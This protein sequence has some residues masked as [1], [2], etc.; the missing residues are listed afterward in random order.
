LLEC[1]A[2]NP[3]SNILPSTRYI[4]RN[5]AVMYICGEMY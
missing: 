2:I 1:S 5:R 3:A 4:L